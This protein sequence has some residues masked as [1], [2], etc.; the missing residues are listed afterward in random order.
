M[1]N[2]NIKTSLAFSKEEGE[3]VKHFYENINII[4]V[5]K[6]HPGSWEDDIPANLGVDTTPKYL[7]TWKGLQHFWKIRAKINSQKQWGV[8]WIVTFISFFTFFILLITQISLTGRMVSGSK[9]V[10]SL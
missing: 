5:I 9:A 8:P 10:V 2:L 7:G 6:P 4:P 1:K 3:L